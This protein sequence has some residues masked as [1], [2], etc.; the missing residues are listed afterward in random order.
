M[1]FFNKSNLVRLR[2]H[3]DKYLLAEDDLHKT[4]RQ[5]RNESSRKVIW[6]V[7]LVEGNCHL[8]RLKSSSGQY[9]TATEEAF[10]LGMTGK[11]VFQTSPSP[12]KVMAHSNPLTEW[13]PIR[14]GFQVKL[15]TKSRT[16]LRANGGTKPWRNTITHDVPQ[17][18]STHNWILWDV[19]A[20]DASELNNR[21]M[22]EFESQLSRFSSNVSNFSEDYS[23][24]SPTSPWSSQSTDS[25]VK[26]STQLGMEFFRRAKTVRLKGHHKKYLIAEEDEESVTQGRDGS[27]KAARWTVEFLEDESFI[28][29]KSC[30]GKYLT[31]SNSPFLLGM[32]GNK[33][34]QSLP[35]RLDSSVEW[36][37]IKDHHHV[38]LKT[39]YGNF[40]RANGG[41]P[42]WRNSV[43]HDVPH[44]T[45]TQEWVL[46]DIDVLE[47]EVHADS[48]KPVIIQE[49]YS[50]PPERSP[51]PEM[52]D[53]YM[54]KLESSRSFAHSNSN[55]N[56]FQKAA[57]GRV[58]HYTIADD[59]GD[60]DEGIEGDSFTFK[61]AGV[62]DLTHKLE[63]ETGLE[64]IIVCTRSPVNGK[65]I[66][67]RLRLPP[68]N[69]TMH[70]VVIPQSSR[71]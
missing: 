41:L 4:V 66:P 63:E 67:L 47:I 3:L 68:N 24:S 27:S 12:G 23:V 69:A 1:E 35:R 46:W 28:R 30:F 60:V 53:H 57:E 65:L 21:S 8:I 43:T 18:S 36:E 15:R 42:P 52:G 22:V 25:P 14:D 71:G 10:L 9:L 11:K 48:P 19:I 45:A 54:L 29:L 38:K 59:N 40:L 32:T 56:S 16:F 44:R 7:E 62:Y 17:R 6:T 70:V 49:V 39:R 13:E 50:P 26:Y 55:S 37:P 31:A 33:V 20:V 5:S 34:T 2:S 51:E 58:V 64:D 61:G